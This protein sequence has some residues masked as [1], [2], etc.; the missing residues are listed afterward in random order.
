MPSG[1]THFSISKTA[2]LIP[3]LEGLCC[4]PTVCHGFACTFTIY[5]VNYK[6]VIPPPPT[7]Q[8]LSILLHKVLHTTASVFAAAAVFFA[9]TRVFSSAGCF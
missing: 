1:Y 4:V 5:C 8:E 6:L 2:P 9:P 3:Q 7:Q